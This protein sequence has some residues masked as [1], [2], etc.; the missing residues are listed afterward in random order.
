M[1]ADLEEQLSITRAASS[2]KIGELESALKL[3]KSK[4]I[5]QG[6]NTTQVDVLNTATSPVVENNENVGTQS[7][8]TKSPVISP[9]ERV[10]AILTADYA[11]KES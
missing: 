4:F 8:E 11:Q 9:G 3:S 10:V 6:I 5:H 7:V 1:A 2:Q